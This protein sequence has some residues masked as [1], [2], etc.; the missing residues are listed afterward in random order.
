VT[1]LAEDLAGR[2]RKD[3]PG[4]FNDRLGD[5]MAEISAVCELSLKGMFGFCP[6]CSPKVNAQK[7]LYICGEIV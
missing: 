2:A 4:A 6:D 1:K 7:L 5:A 3:S